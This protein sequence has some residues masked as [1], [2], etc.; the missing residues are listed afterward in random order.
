MRCDDVTRLLA[1]GGALGR[2]R[3][4]RHMVRC[5]RC[6]ALRSI[7][8]DLATVPHLPDSHRALWARAA[9][10][11]TT[12]R[13]TRPRYVRPALVGLAAAAVL[14]IAIRLPWVTAP[15]RPAPRDVPVER[16]LE[17]AAATIR[18]LDTIKDSL[19]PLAR[20]LADLRRRADLLD[21]RRDV[22]RLLARYAWPEKPRGM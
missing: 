18:S 21:A 17:L 14:L 2:W 11:A 15:P 7:L 20:E 22:D 8:D 4:R 1:T 19:D 12:V 9:D 3:V 16:G 10:E 6:A 13:L 5:P